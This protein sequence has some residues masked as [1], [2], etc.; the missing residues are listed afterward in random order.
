MEGRVDTFANRLAIAMK[1]NNINQI[2]LS[3]KTKAFPKQI[4]QSLINKYLKGKAFARQNN[5]YILCKIL[6]V[7][8]A[9]IMGFDVPME[10]TPDELRGE[11]LKTDKLGNP[12]S[13]IA[14]LGMVKAGYNYMAQENWDD[15]IE[16]DKNLIKD[17]SEYFALKIKGDS[18]FPVLVEDDIVIIKKQ[19]DFETGDI[20]VA[21]VNG[22]E[23]TIKKG[24]KTNNGILLQPF[25]TKY[26]PLVFAYD[27]MKTIPVII[28]GIV[29]QLKRE[30]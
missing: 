27:E 1:K 26:E 21:I 11:K 4:S 10:R 14:L 9:W 29:K 5:I 6:N 23:A 13:E 30:F 16:V 18:M 17:G 15:M 28:V 25:N 8:E 19:S 2:E 7:D 24:K 22:D 3:E 20:V 12:I